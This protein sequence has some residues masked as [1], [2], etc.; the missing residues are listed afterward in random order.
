[1]T[2]YILEKKDEVVY[3][4]IFFQLQKKIKYIYN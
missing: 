4:L 2:R 3:E 1:M